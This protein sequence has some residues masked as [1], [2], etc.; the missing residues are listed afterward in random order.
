[1]EIRSNF[2]FTLCKP[3]FKPYNIQ[4]IALSNGRFYVLIYLNQNPLQN[5]IL[6]YNVKTSKPD[7][8]LLLNGLTSLSIKDIRKLFE[9]TF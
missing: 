3:N 8:H 1:M 5:L 6:L 4:P 2:E 9:S 7:H